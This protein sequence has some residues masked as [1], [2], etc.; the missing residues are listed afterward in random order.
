MSVPHIIL[1]NLPSL[2]LN[3]QIWWK[4]DVLITKIILLVF[5]RHGIHDSSHRYGSTAAGQRRT[6]VCLHRR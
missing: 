1:D 6:C 5:L 2:C 4:F 3:C